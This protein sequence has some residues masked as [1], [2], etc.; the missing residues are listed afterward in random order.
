M[1]RKDPITATVLAIWDRDHV[2]CAVHI[3]VL[4]HCCGLL[5]RP[6]RMRG[7]RLVGK[8]IHCDAFAAPEERDLLVAGCIA[9]W[10]LR[11]QGEI[12]GHQRIERC[13]REIMQAL[14][15]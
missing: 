7:A 8:E 1:T 9:Q 3:F 11:E 15:A 2:A 12:A 4:A 14:D 13:A 6:A 10:V 5:T